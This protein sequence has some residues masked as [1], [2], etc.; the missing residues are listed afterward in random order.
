MGPLFPRAQIEGDYPIFAAD[1]DPQDATN[2]ITRDD[3]GAGTSGADSNFASFCRVG[4]HWASWHVLLLSIERFC[5]SPVP[6]VHN[7]KT[8]MTSDIAQDLRQFAHILQDQ[9]VP[10]TH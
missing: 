10:L 2:L 4:V 1:L 9:R 7:C 8:I 5:V 3:D 6:S